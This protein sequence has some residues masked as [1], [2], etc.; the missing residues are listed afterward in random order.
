MTTTIYGQKHKINIEAET[1]TPPQFWIKVE[2]KDHC[3]WS[4]SLHAD[5]VP[6]LSSIPLFLLLQGPP[7]QRQRRRLLS[8]CLKL[9]TGAAWLGFYRRRPFESFIWREFRGT[10]GG[11][12]RR[13][14][15]HKLLFAK[16]VHNPLDLPF[17]RAAASVSQR[18][19][20]GLWRRF[21]GDLRSRFGLRF[22]GWRRR[23][24]LGCFLDRHGSWSLLSRCVS[25]PALTN[26]RSGFEGKGQCEQVI[27]TWWVKREEKKVWYY[28]KCNV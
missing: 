19:G 11:L 20:A 10:V 5:A 22:E 27:M 14:T 7:L 4:T 23:G 12:S 2:V 21:W 25:L 15:R 16:L 13:V 1:E 26:Q 9:P 18:R 28:S 24:P 3:T 17:R 6:L 8:P